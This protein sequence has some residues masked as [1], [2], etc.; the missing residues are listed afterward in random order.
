QPQPANVEHREAELT[1]T[2]RNRCLC[3]WIVRGT[4]AVVPSI[5]PG[6]YVPL[7]T[8]FDRAGQVDWTSLERLAADVLDDGAVGLVA[9]GTTGEPAT[10]SRRERD[11][12]IACCTAVCADRGR[13]LIVGVGGNDTA[14]VAT[15]VE[16]RSAKVDAILSV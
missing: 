16:R 15:E 3:Y 14:A 12:V 10:L 8:P 5:G 6:I 1:P 13:P 9:L 7:V 2:A 4:L 11:G